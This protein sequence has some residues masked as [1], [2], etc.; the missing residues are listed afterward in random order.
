MSITFA[1]ST[2]T[3]TKSC[4]YSFV[5][6]QTDIAATCK[7]YGEVQVK[8]MQ[9][10]IENL[11]SQLLHISHSNNNKS[12]LPSV[13]MFEPLTCECGNKTVLE[14]QYTN[15]QHVSMT[16]R[17]AQNGI[18]E[19]NPVK[20]TG[21]LISVLTFSESGEN[22]QSVNKYWSLSTY[23]G[24]KA[25]CEFDDDQ[26]A[27]TVIMRR[28]KM[29]V[30][31]NRTIEEYVAGFGD[32]ESGDFWLGLENMHKLT[33]Q[34]YSK[35]TLW[36]VIKD[37]HRIPRVMHYDTFRVGNNNSGYDIE[38]S[39]FKGGA[40]KDY[41]LVSMPFIAGNSTLI[42]EK[43]NG[44]EKKTTF[45]KKREP[46]D[47]FRFGENTKYGGWWFQE[48]VQDSYYSRSLKKDCGS[49]NLN[50]PIPYWKGFDKIYSV[51]MK[52]RTQI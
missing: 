15:C 51:E 37:Q 5:V 42:E 18:Y 34:M 6:P 20:S 12:S 39:G 24:L 13:S 23:D 29:N 36:I 52:I 43:K 26:V 14:Q 40:E 31:F 27:W 28:K 30:S 8:Q 48:Y 1:Q 47:C 9:K 3:N 7:S 19:L 25:Y 22:M 4:T 44:K 2:E 10:Q 50:A 35:Y 21:P 32:M 17:Y 41:L 11:Q 33:N 38:T 16:R 45:G 49:S 46:E